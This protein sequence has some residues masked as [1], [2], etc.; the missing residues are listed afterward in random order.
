M[1]PTIRKIKEEDIPYLK[2]VL[3]SIELFPADM[4]D[5]MISD[6]FND[7]ASLDF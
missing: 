6:F 2:E 5:D 1:N 3:N 4:L 7:P